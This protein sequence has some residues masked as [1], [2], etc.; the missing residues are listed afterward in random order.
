VPL[1]ITASQRNAIRD[2]ILR[3][4]AWPDGTESLRAALPNLSN[5]L[6]V[7]RLLH[8]AGEVQV[9]RAVTI[10]FASEEYLEL[11]LKW[12]AALDRLHLCNYLVVCA[13][14]PSYK[15]ITASGI[16]A[17]HAN[18]DAG[19][20]AFPSH[21][22]FTPKGASIVT[23]RFPVIRAIL[24]QGFDVVLSDADA[25]WCGDPHPHFPQHADL[26][27][28]RI[29]VHPPEMVRAWGF[30]LCSGFVFYRHTPATLAFLDDC[31]SYNTRVICDQVAAN[32]ALLG[33][34][35]TWDLPESLL[36]ELPITDATAKRHFGSHS[37]LSFQGVG[38][39]YPLTAIALSPEQFWRHRS[40]QPSGMV[41]CHPNSPKSQPE[42]LQILSQ[43]L[44]KY[45]SQ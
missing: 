11:A 10:T 5:A 14:A 44:E 30:G 21:S 38:S 31:I 20:D 22:G 35:M 19:C 33:S 6:D 28:Q 29:A 26:A 13:D 8:I 37:A 12:T 41:V 7:D 42:K 27:F 1:Q 39:T 15:A 18:I 3:N 36:R 43:C 4:Y 45:Q 9:R 25:I 34:D 32:L 23:L 16:P 40:I 24:S 17:I 2:D